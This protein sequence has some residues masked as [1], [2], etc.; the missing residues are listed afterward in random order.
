MENIP[1]KPIT[2]EQELIDFIYNKKTYIFEYYSIY[3]LLSLIRYAK[4]D[5][6]KILYLLDNYSK[7]ENLEIIEKS[8]SI[9]FI[10]NI[11]SNQLSQEKHIKKVEKF[12][13][14]SKTMNQIEETENKNEEDNIVWNFIFSVSS[15]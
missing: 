14:K 3:D 4:N 13:I 11:N 1:E 5:K 9:N 10:S 8:K 6:S 12:M 15:I 7:E 2:K